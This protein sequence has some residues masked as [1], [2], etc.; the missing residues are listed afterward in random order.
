MP[1]LQRLLPITLRRLL[2]MRLL[3]PILLM[4]RLLMLKLLPIRLKNKQLVLL[5]RLRQQRLMPMLPRL[6]LTKLMLL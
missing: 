3:R 5:L 1:L 4:R 6:L 2:M